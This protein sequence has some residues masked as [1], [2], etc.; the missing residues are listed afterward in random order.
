MV[1]SL[2]LPPN[3]TPD[4]RFEAGVVRLLGSPISGRLWLK[5]TLNLLRADS[6]GLYR[7]SPLGIVKR[8]PV[9]Q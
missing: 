3:E 9:R 7:P 2:K 8:S 6:S 4:S 5:Q 1:A